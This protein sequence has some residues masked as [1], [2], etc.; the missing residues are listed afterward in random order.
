MSTHDIFRAKEMADT[1]G[2]MTAGKLV[3]NKTKAELENADLNQIY[4]DYI[5]ERQ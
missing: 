2:I 4:L 1:V 3:G 5:E